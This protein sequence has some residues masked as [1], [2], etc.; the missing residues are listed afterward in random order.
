MKVA[1]IL[2]EKGRRVVSTQLEVNVSDV[3]ELLREEGIGAALV[4]QGD[5]VI[6]GI[7]SERD[8]V[9]GFA[10]HGVRLS[11]MTVADLM[12]S[13]VITCSPETETDELMEQM[14]SG[15]FRHL[16]VVENGNLVGI[17]SIGDVVR[18]VFSEL[19][20]IRSALE[21]QVVRS[22]AWATDED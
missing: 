4:E 16:P 22:T 1:D 21:D 2:K 13:S 19:K 18:S 3:A 14:L 10:D 15:H 20:W 7:I 5:G 9:R 12:T 8:I 6:A 11:E 17:I